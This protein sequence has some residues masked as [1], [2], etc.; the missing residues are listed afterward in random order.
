MDAHPY[1]LIIA[2]VSVV[3]FAFVVAIAFYITYGV[4]RNIAAERQKLRILQEQEK[5]EYRLQEAKRMVM[6]GS[7]AGGM[8]YYLNH[9]MFE[10]KELIG[11]MNTGSKMRG[12]VKGLLN[13]EIQQAI[14]I[15]DQLQQIAHPEEILLRPQSAIDLID[16]I[17]PRIISLLLNTINFS[18]DCHQ[19]CDIIQGDHLLLEQALL[20]MVTNAIDAMPEG[21][22]LTVDL[23]NTN[24]QSTDDNYLVLSISDTGCG[25]DEETKS[26][27]FE[28]FF[29]KNKRFDRLGL[30][31][32]F[33][34][35]ILQ[36]HKGHLEITSELNQGT[37]IS[38]FL[39]VASHQDIVNYASRK[40][41]KEFTTNGSKD[42]LTR[43]DI[44]LMKQGIMGRT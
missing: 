35:G 18:I 11:L 38:L 13:N 6:I 32:S 5:L 21:G 43:E 39:P 7:L 20:N 40:E 16:S 37:T 41:Y 33:V 14:Q 17:K 9:T 19:D 25:M 4:K 8:A 42:S 22:V 2:T 1:Y 44:I 10:I 15:S 23:S 27:V 28:P 12:K 26:K 24:G 36:I 34:Y 3:L 30:G 29:T 31:L